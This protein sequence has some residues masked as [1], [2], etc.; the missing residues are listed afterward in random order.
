MGKRCA[1]A[2]VRTLY[3]LGSR[4]GSAALALRKATLH[5]AGRWLCANTL[6][7]KY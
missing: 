1:W 6:Q 2:S 4:E 3:K 7:F 5:K